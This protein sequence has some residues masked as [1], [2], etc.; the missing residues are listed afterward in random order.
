MNKFELRATDKKDHFRFF[1]NGVDLIVEQEKSVYR[2]IIQVMD[3][4]INTGL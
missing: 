2:H 3:N 1:A 4:N